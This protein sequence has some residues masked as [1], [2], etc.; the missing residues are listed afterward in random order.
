VAYGIGK[1]AC[2]RMAADI[3]LELKDDNVTSIALWPGAV[4]TELVE[5]T[6]FAKPNAAQMIFKDAES[7]E[8]AGKCLVDFAADPNLIKKTGRIVTTT[9]LAIE[10]SLRDEDGSVPRNAHAEIY[11]EFLDDLNRV[12]TRSAI[13][14]IKAHI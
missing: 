11:K 6:V 7:V 2:D 10:Y 3:A 8:F 1:A 12:R 13:E 4:R 14:D 5:Q 9:E